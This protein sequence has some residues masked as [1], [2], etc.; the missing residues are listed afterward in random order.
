[1]NDEGEYPNGVIGFEREAR[2]FAYDP[3]TDTIY[4]TTGHHPDIVRELYNVDTY[5][6][7]GV[8]AFAKAAE[9]YL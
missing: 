1:M 3:A 6:D 9:D 4:T 5:G 2:A 7:E 8:E